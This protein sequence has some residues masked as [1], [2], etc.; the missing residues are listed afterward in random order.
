MRGVIAFALPGF[1]SLLPEH[2]GAAGRLV[3]ERFPNQE[4][5][6]GVEAPVEGQSCLLVG[7]VAPPDEQLLSLLLAADTLNR[8]GASRITALLPYLAYARQGAGAEKEPGTP[9]GGLLSACGR[10]SCHD[11][12]AQPRRGR[13]A[14]GPPPLPL[15]GGPVCRRDRAGGAS[16]CSRRRP[17]RGSRGALPGGRRGCGHREARCLPEKGADSLR[18]RARR[19]G[20]AAGPARCRGRRHS[21]H[22]RNAPLLLPGAATPR[23]GADDGHGHP[24]PLHRRGV[25]R[26]SLAPERIY[27]IEG[28]PDLFGADGRAVIL[29]V[30]PRSK[31]AASCSERAQAR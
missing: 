2:S 24:R 15:A 12:R 31:A 26:P 25:E 23:C 6:L 18:D 13:L 27:V 10:P 8:Q 28:V 20:G 9:G 3:V 1:E 29:E 5:S 21:R 17:G 22:W 14:R 30:R 19:A 11:R 7:S 4:L 16:R